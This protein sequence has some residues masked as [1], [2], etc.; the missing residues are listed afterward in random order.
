MISIKIEGIERVQA[1]FKRLG[2]AGEKALSD[3][4]KLTAVES[5]SYM[6]T[7]T[8]RVTGR[9]ISSMH[10][11]TAK[12]TQF[13]YTDQLGKSFD[14]KFPLRLANLEAAFG[15]NVNYADAAN[16]KSSQPRFKEKATNYAAD[17]IEANTIKYYNK[18]IDNAK[19]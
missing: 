7:Q 15:T 14:G 10:V 13:T 2:K 17:R 4:V 9:L 6:Q 12:T 11:E 19:K 3:A 18:V 5:N 16:A 8:P 1:M